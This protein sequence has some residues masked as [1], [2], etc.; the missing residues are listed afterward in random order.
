MPTSRR[1]GRASIRLQ[2]LSVG[3]VGLLGAMLGG[4]AAWVGLTQAADAARQVNVAL[5]TEGQLM[6]LS[7]VGGSVIAGVTAVQRDTLAEG[8][9]RAAA[10]G[11]AGVTQY[12]A[13]LQRARE[14]ASRVDASALPPESQQR[15][16]SATTA[17]QE[18]DADARRAFEM[19]ARGDATSVR[20]GSAILAREV[21]PRLEVFRSEGAQ[22]T[23]AA[24]ATAAQAVADERAAQMRAL[25]VML[26][27]VAVVGGLF[28]GMAW[29]VSGR[30]SRSLGEVRTSVR[31]LARGDL[32]VECVPRTKD[33]VGDI[34]AAV[35]QARVWLS[36]IV[37]SVTATS[38][39]VTQRSGS[40]RDMV[41]AMRAEATE[42]TTRAG[43]MGDAAG[44]VSQHVETVATGTEQ[45][46]ASIREIATSAT[47]AAD[48][49]A[50]AVAVADQTNLTV[51]SLG[52]SSAEI[53]EV[54][55][56]ITQIAEQTNLL[57]LNATIEAARAGEAGKGFAVVAG[58]VKE[59]AHE[60]GRATEDISRRVE[61]IQVD[62][63]AAVAAIEQI[64]GIIGRIN[65]TQSAIA[66][67]VDEQTAT[68]GEISRSILDAS[69]GA[70]HIASEVERTTEVFR[71]SEGRTEDVVDLVAELDAVAGE[72]TGL[73]SRFAY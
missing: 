38:A 43:R 45:M 31:A 4:G 30:I 54:V 64:S 26:G 33:E 46:T 19:V 67:A 9:A 55:K 56:T 18:A 23:S 29:W 15:L 6:A 51:A 13:G 21:T 63:E 69:G 72:L 12:T 57:A 7:E 20:Q 32:R 48:V 22:L 10:P 24:A 25:S 1:V 73:V 66:S 8:G 3:A 27:A 28:V 11:S 41:A 71:R 42:G 40:L 2:V 58:E 60:T 50:G 16:A 44:A 36:T 47:D 17:V 65:D 34:A 53:G 62:T 39:Q 35:E 70:Q 68:T 52:R 14:L 49:A 5:T 61:Q 37:A 59:L